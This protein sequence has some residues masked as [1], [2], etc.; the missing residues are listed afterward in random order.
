MTFVKITFE[1]RADFPPAGDAT[2]TGELTQRRLQ[3]EDRDSTSKQEDEVWDEEGPCKSTQIKFT[4]H[5][6]TFKTL[7]SDV[8]EDTG[9]GC[10]SWLIHLHCEEMFMVLGGF[11]S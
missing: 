3:E 5:S 2:L 7:S 9:A 6:H 1:Q 10:A 11:L 4:V 8:K